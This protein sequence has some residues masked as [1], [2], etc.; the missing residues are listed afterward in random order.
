MKD[1]TLPT[2]V[3]LIQDVLK[4]FATNASLVWWVICTYSHSGIA[5]RSRTKHIGTPKLFMHWLHG[6][7]LMFLGC[8]VGLTMIS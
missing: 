2:R 6:G 3:T 1:C 8:A 7:P 4:T 5:K